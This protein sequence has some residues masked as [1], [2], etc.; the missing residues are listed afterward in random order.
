MATAAPDSSTESLNE[1]VRRNPLS[2][3]VAIIISNDYKYSKESSLEGPQKDGERMRIAFS[4]LKI[5]NIWRHN[6]TN[7][8]LIDLLKE[9]AQVAAHFP[10]KYESISFVFS[11]HGNENIIVL[12]DDSTV[13]IH[14]I[15]DAFSP[16]KVPEIADIPKLFFI[17][18]CRGGKHIRPL[19][20]PARPRHRHEEQPQPSTFLTP[21]EGNFLIAYSTLAPYVAHDTSDGSVWMKILADTMC[22]ST[23]HIEEVLTQVRQ[24]L[25]THYQAHESKVQLPETRSTLLKKVFFNRVTRSVSLASRR[26]PERPSRMHPGVCMHAVH[27]SQISFGTF[28]RHDEHFSHFFKF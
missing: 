21:P 4:R 11:G 3:G 5:A 18:A 17:D 28:G 1:L 23:N 8:Q 13:N 14:Q 12:Q 24:D 25:H 20:V 22:K 27:V 19:R 9:V 10:S 7:Y 15:I 16:R 2:R 6:V 26:P